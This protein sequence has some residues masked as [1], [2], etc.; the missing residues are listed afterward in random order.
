MKDRVSEEGREEEGEVCTMFEDM[1][2]EVRDEEETGGE[3][4][5]KMGEQALPLSPANLYTSSTSPVTLSR[6]AKTRLLKSSQAMSI[7]TRKSHFRSLVITSTW[8]L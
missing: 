2:E 7:L 1:K 8:N 6:Y 5:A 4:E 3:E